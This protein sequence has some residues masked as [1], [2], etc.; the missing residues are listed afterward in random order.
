MK[1]S[2]SEECAAVA[3]ILEKSGIGSSR[4][5]D[6]IV[7]N[8][9]NHYKRL[10]NKLK[11]A[12]GGASKK[13]L[14][15]LWEKWESSYTL[16]IL[17]NEVDQTFLISH[18]GNKIDTMI[19]MEAPTNNKTFDSVRDLFR[20]AILKPIQNTRGPTKRKSF[21]DYSEKQKKRI[22]QKIMIECNNSIASICD[23]YNVLPVEMEIMN[24]VTNKH[25]KKSS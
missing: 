1:K 24:L 10:V 3:E 13:R 18:Y 5:S 16:T 6:R 22:K 19:K 11:M 14:C 4:L 23:S 9:L 20:L 2:I 8:V 21:E 25:P 15:L 17:Q 7:H 12:K